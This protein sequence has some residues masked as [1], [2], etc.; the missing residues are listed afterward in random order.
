MERGGTVRPW[1]LYIFSYGKVKENR[2]LGTGFFVHH[3][4]ISALKRVEIVSDRMTYLV[5]LKGRWFNVFG[6][7]A[8]AAREEKTDDS[9]DSFY[10]ELELVFDHFPK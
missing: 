8:H 7:N 6:L 4:L 1:G 2:Q 9:N 3:R 5:V 10:E